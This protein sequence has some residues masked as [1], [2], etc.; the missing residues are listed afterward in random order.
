MENF[1]LA[2]V[3]SRQNQVRSH[4]GRSF[5]R[6]VRSQLG[7]LACLTG[8]AHFDMNSPLERISHVLLK[9]FTENY[10][11]ANPGEYHVVLNKNNELCLY[12][13][14]VSIYDLSVSN[15]I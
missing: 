12:Q 5:L 8:P 4:L 3:G 7:E 9:W 6:K 11:Q 10:L 13:M 14:S 15:M 1:H 2:Y